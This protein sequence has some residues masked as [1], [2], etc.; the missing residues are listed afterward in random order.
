MEAGQATEVKGSRPWVWTVLCALAV[1]L[2]FAGTLN[3][4]FVNWDDG[5]YID[6][7]SMVTD[8]GSHGIRERLTT[9]NLGYPLPLPVWLYGFVWGWGGRATAFHALSLLLHALN[10]V[11]FQRLLARELK[12]PKAAAFAALA[13]A[14]HPIV[15]EPVA[16]ATGLKDLLVCTGTL[17]ALHGLRRNAVLGIPGTLIALASKPSAALLGFALPFFT[18]GR[19]GQRGKTLHR[20]LGFG[21]AALAGVVVLLFSKLQ[22]TAELQ[23]TADTGFSGMRVVGALGLQAQHV[24]VPASLSPLYPFESVTLGHGIVGAAVIVAVLLGLWRLWRARSAALGWLVLACALYLPT[25]N[26]IPLIRYTAD[27]YVYVSW[28]AIVA[29]CAHLWLAKGAQ[30]R[31]RAGRS[32]RLLRPA[33]IVFLVAWAGLSALQVEM[34]SST[35]SLWQAAAERYPEDGE[36]VYRYG[37]ALGREGALADELALYFEHQEALA[38]SPKIP[39]ALLVFHESEGNLD[40]ATVWYERGFASD[41]KQEHGFYWH[42]VEFVARYPE[43]HS[44]GRDAGLAHALGVYVETVERSRLD[45]PQLE[46]MATRAARLGRTDAADLL[47]AEARARVSHG[48]EQP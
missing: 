24:F 15:V 6:S 9:P 31:E 1:A 29:V 44:A 18:V 37:D 32:A 10:A 12:S 8:P 43:R 4:E 30:W 45:T 39:A 47:R 25:S 5:I 38:R 40:E 21:T 20:V 2:V 3:N 19:E 42:Y 46:R 36:L 17:V 35:R 28:M 13:F 23:T 22:E 34:W 48:S 14:L 26:L 11:L 27:S 7:N 41:V 16:W 33:G